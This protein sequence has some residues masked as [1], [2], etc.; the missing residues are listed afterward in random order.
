LRA[1][2]CSPIKLVN[3]VWMAGTKD[4]AAP[5]RGSCLWGRLPR[6]YDL[7]S[8]MEDFAALPVPTGNIAD[9]LVPHAQKSEEYLS[10]TAP[11]KPPGRFHWQAD[12]WLYP[13][14]A[15]R[16]SALRNRGQRC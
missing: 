14:G 13:P 6:T 15:R 7:A 16:R 3:D 12:F 11:D 4:C 9:A 5:F 8:A 1:H 10:V 2:K